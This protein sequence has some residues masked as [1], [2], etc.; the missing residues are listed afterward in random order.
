MSK[1]KSNK[2]EQSINVKALLSTIVVFVVI[3][4]FL[5]VYNIKTIRNAT[6]EKARI[7][8]EIK[9]LQNEFDDLLIEKQKLIAHDRIEKIA[10]EELGLVPNLKV[11]EKI[12]IDKRELDYIK[13]IVDE[14]Y[15]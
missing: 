1:K 2:N 11:N 6:R 3:G 13:R 15:E 12:I 5:H 9:A 7:L 8:K 14:K 10:K 4:L